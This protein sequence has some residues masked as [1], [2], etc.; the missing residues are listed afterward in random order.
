M[1]AKHIVS[2]VVI[3]VLLLFG[4]YY[5]KEAT[6]PGQYDDFAQCIA[7]SGTIFY[8]AFWCP[9]CQ[10]QKELFGKSEKR[11]KY[12][13]CST[14]NGQGQL[15]VCVDAGIQAYPT[16]EFS[17]GERVTGVLPLE[18]LAEKTGCELSN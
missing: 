12:I 15:P 2:G 7:D 14:A 8:G 17:G 16:W 9:N 5:Y 6:T 4:Y 10:N 18:T 11:L 3:A 1:N 13:E